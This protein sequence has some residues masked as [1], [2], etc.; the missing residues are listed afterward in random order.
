M[1]NSREQ[2]YWPGFVDALSNVV[3]TLVFVL[4]VFVFA[5]VIASNKVERRAT[6]II[7]SVKEEAAKD[8]N[9]SQVIALKEDLEKA[10]EQIKA[11]QEKEKAPE[12]TSSVEDKTDIAVEKSND[13]IAVGAVN[14]SQ[15]HG[16]ISITFPK[17]VTNLDT[18]S[19]DELNRILSPLMKNAAK[20]KVVLLSY[21]GEESYSAARRLAY[22]RALALRNHIIGKFGAQGANITNRIVQP[23]GSSNGRVEIILE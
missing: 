19:Y 14:I 22:Y 23:E 6:E 8:T 7:L 20:Q 11:L 18:K 12:I 21:I 10:R 17:A 13:L 16:K 2:N 3:L 1:E 5:L 4:V 9:K 15:S